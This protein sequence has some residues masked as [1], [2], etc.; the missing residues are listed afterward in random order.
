MS[1]EQVGGSGEG[2]DAVDTRSDVYALGVVAY[3]LLTGTLPYDVSRRSIVDAARI[4]RAQH[5]KKL[6]VITRTLRGDV[7]TIV[8]KALEKEPARRYQSAAALAEDVRRVLSHQPILARRASA[9]Y[10]FRK[11]VSRHKV[12]FAFI[13]AMFILVNGFAAWM[14]VEYARAERLRVAAEEAGRAEREQREIAINK[15]LA[16]TRVKEALMDAFS[17]A[18][19]GASISS[20]ITVRQVL[21]RG[22]EKVSRSLRDEPEMQADFQEYLAIMYG[23]IGLLDR[24]KELLETSMATRKRLFGDRDPHVAK[25]LCNMGELLRTRGD[26]KGAE[27]ACREALEIYRSVSAEDDPNVANALNV[28]AGVLIDKGEYTTAEAMARES[29]SLHQRTPGHQN[30]VMAGS[31]NNLA[32]LMQAR[33]NYELAESLMREAL[34]ITESGGEVSPEG[35][36]V[37]SM[38]NNLAY[39]LCMKGEFEEAE[40]RARAG[41][42]IRE[43]LYPPGHELIASSYLVVGLVLTDSGRAGEGE[44]YLR[45]C[46]DIRKKSL[47]DSRAKIAEAENALAGCLGAQGLHEEAEPML[48]S[49]LG[50]LQTELGDASD[51]TQVALLRTG[52]F[53]EAWGRPG[54]AEKYRKLLRPAAVPQP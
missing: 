28:L 33:G 8:L 19:P 26:L 37:A 38:L 51:V 36:Q 31:L 46:V 24:A 20:P 14:S 25:S 10:Q 40:K 41:L 2:G 5:P 49:S 7:E 30:L 4:I 3:E 45:D 52:G 43:K 54:Q 32:N 11:L 15:A 35:R 9:A 22:A 1:P 48:L 53:Y 17:V 6:S 13:V 29:V 47:P 27:S 44:K 42:A 39:V 12:S 23:N 50:V 34:S 16:A 21:D 18:E